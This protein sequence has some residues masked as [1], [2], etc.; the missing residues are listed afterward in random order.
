[1]GYTHYW[2]FKRPPTAEE[3]RHFSMLASTLVA[4][5]RQAGILGDEMG[6]DRASTLTNTAVGFN[7]LGANSHETFRISTKSSGFDFCKTARKPYDAYVC[8]ALMVARSV[9]PQSV[10]RISSDGDWDGSTYGDDFWPEWVEGR[11]LFKR[12]YEHDPREDT[13]GPEED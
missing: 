5:G 6:E 3:V 12:L 9:W 4:H 2:T 10:L 1:M 8:C 11:D 13:L 7:G